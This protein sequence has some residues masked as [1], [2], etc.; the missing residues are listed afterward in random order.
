MKERV[1]LGN[2]VLLISEWISSIWP[3]TDGKKLSKN[4]IVS[5]EYI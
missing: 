2:T 4:V 1:N 5:L 3:R